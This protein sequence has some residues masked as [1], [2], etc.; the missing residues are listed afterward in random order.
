M[1]VGVAS[2][3]AFRNI[4]VHPGH[5]YIGADSTDSA[6][7]LTAGFGIDLE[8]DVH[9][10]EIIF[11]GTNCLKCLS[12]EEILGIENPQLGQLIAVKQ[13][14]TISALAVYNGLNWSK[15]DLISTL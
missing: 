6:V 5:H 13:D 1:G 2:A 10:K 12:K 7:Q 11:H 3:D 8:V 14:D 15:V 9:S 4:I